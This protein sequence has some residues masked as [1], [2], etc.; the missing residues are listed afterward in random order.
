MP[1]H[2]KAVFIFGVWLAACVYS[3]AQSAPP[4]PV[5]TLDVSIIEARQ[6]VIAIVIEVPPQQERYDLT[7]ATIEVRETIKGPSATRLTVMLQANP[8]TVQAWKK[9]GARLLVMIR[10]NDAEKRSEVVDLSSK[11]LA[12]MTAD[13]ELAR[14]PE[15]VIRAAKEAVGA[16]SMP[17]AKTFALR[18]PD[19]ALKGTRFERYGWGDFV[20][21]YVPIDDRLQRKAL[22]LIESPNLMDRLIGAH[23][24]MHFKSAS[25]IARLRTLLADAGWEYWRW[26][27]NYHIIQYKQYP[28][29]Q[30]AYEIL[31]KFGAAVVRPVVREPEREEEQ[32]VAA[33]LENGR[34][35][36]A[37]ISELARYP[38]LEDLYLTNTKL[39]KADLSPIAQLKG[40][41]TLYLHGSDITDGGLK[42]LTK[43]PKLLYL[44]LGNT[45]V[46]DAGLR[47]LASIA[48]L[49]RVDLGRRVTKAGIGELRRLRPDLDVRPD[50]FAFLA[51][52]RPRR[53]DLAMSATRNYFLPVGQFY[54][55]AAG[56]HAYALIFPKETAAGAR[57]LLDKELRRRGWQAVGTHNYSRPVKT[58]LP[59]VVKAKEDRVSIDDIEYHGSDIVPNAFVK[60]G[61]RLVYIIL[62]VE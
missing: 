5:P 6:V 61:E 62:G 15:E 25:N 29:R 59:G 18:V 40:L 10:L 36:G 21:F 22:I 1:S 39:K 33:E 48:S 47:V 52:L 7:K 3:F 38:N 35:T 28:V 11:D 32:V 14:R 43:L 20:E 41:R 58:N 27:K 50:E 54:R 53:V 34:V 23:A 24:L 9:S 37:Q 49:K 42:P 13:L 45:N 16:P 31:R 46:T 30:A 56:G 51:R 8:P 19:A 4:R 26:A 57:A 12:V 55:V 17:A 2:F 60:P 44:G